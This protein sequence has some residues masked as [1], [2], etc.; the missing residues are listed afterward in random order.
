MMPS[1]GSRR[2]TWSG[3]ASKSTIAPPAAPITKLAEQ[4]RG[5]AVTGRD[6]CSK[7]SASSTSR[8]RT[9]NGF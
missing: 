8:Q 4:V 5:V 9:W 3:L 6:A 2:L 1:S 7:R